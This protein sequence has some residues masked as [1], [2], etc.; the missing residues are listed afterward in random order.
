MFCC[1]R[2]RHASTDDRLSWLDDELA[3]WYAAAQAEATHAEVA[4]G[5]ATLVEVASHAEA[6]GNP[7]ADPA[8]APCPICFEAVG[9]KIGYV[10]VNTHSWE[11]SDRCD[12]HDICQPCLQRYVE[13]KLVEEAIWNIRCPGEA[14]QY[15]LLHQDLEM[16]LKESKYRRK[17]L[18]RHEKLR[19][20]DCG[21]RLG[22]LLQCALQDSTEEWAWNECQACPK[23]LVLARR[24]DGCDHLAC[25]CG[26]HFCWRCG[27][28]YECPEKPCCCGEFELHS[29]QRS[30]LC[31]WLCFKHDDHPALGDL[32]NPVHDKLMSSLP[33][34]ERK[35]RRAERQRAEAERARL[36]EEWADNQVSGTAVALEIRSTLE[37]L[38]PH[39][40]QAGA[41]VQVQ[42]PE[43]QESFQG[44]L[45]RRRTHAME[46]ND[47]DWNLEWWSAGPEFEYEE[48]K[49]QRA[50]HTRIDPL[51]VVR[52]K[53]WLATDEGT[54][55]KVKVTARAPAYPRRQKQ[56]SMASTRKQVM[57]AHEIRM[58]R[59][60]SQWLHGHCRH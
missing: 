11:N 50:Q 1:H 20:E 60:L 3:A 24:E 7:P 15:R 26:T 47:D 13:T 42:F 29:E 43:I 36:E 49:L 30:F 27:A 14:C 35:L 57:Q 8:M 18:A 39:L 19:S 17:A 32:R 28:D 33:E 22:E 5:E 25:R 34:G 6:V 48:P 41:D 46:N 31:L 21:S 45:V 55:K 9:E 51:R 53:A 16:A 12:G 59:R 23:C 58:A 40:V 38:G 2:R 10:Q 44:F 54:R 52:T 37:S 4:L 56:A